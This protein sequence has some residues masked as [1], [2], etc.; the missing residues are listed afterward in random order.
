MT[1][2]KTWSN[3]EKKMSKFPTNKDFLK[4][5]EIYAEASPDPSRKT[6]CVLTNFEHDPNR[7]WA[8]MHGVNVFPPG[9]TPRLER[10]AKYTFIEHAERIAI[11]T[12]ARLGHM[13]EGSTIYLTWFPCADCARAIVCA[14]IKRLVGYEPDWTEERYGFKDARTILEEGGVEIVFEERP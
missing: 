14:G 4:L 7:E 10:P 9:V 1:F 11:Y 8:Y 6:G 3:L 5:A 2:E 13:T 12:C